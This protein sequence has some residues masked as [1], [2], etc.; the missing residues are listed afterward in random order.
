MRTKQTHDANLAF[1]FG[2]RAFPFCADVMWRRAFEFTWQR[3]RTDPV[4]QISSSSSSATHESGLLFVV[5]D[6]RTHTLAGSRISSWFEK[7]ESECARAALGVLRQH[8]S[9]LPDLIFYLARVNIN[10]NKGAYWLS[11]GA[12]QHITRVG[13]RISL[14]R[15]ERM[16][17]R[18]SAQHTLAH[19]FT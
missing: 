8:A 11:G 18:L 10:L 1:H 15:A 17:E 3:F 6:T 7:R 4:K 5:R 14:A 19:T 13:Q 2:Q 12:F 16:G 9:S